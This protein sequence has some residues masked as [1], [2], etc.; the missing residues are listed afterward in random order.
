MHQLRAT[1]P[2]PL[3][4]QEPDIFYV[5][6]KFIQRYVD[7]KIYRPGADV[8][9]TFMFFHK[10]VYYMYT[11]LYEFPEAPNAL[12]FFASIMSVDAL[13]FFSCDDEAR[14]VRSDADA[15]R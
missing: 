2:L 10:C 7:I 13:L 14:L 15:T 3:L 1:S 6:K 8:Y 5:D 12:M 11:R 4:I 9:V